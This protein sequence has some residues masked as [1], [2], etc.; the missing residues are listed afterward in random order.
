MIVELEN[1]DYQDSAELTGLAAYVRDLYEEFRNSDY[2][3]R[4]IDEINAAKK[5]YQLDLPPKSFPWKDCANYTLALERIAVESIEPRLMSQLI[6][7]DNFVNP[8][9]NGPE[10]VKHT[11]HVRDSVNWMLNS[12]MKIKKIFRP[13]LH[14]LC[15]DGTAD[16]IPVWKEGT[17]QINV[18]YPQPVFSMGDKEVPVSPEVMENPQ[19]MQS[20]AQM[21]LRFAGYK[22]GFRNEDSHWFMTDLEHVP[23]SDAFFP[24]N[25]DNWEN[26]PY[27]RMIYPTL[28][29]LDELS[30]EDG[31]Y[32]NIT[33]DLV[34]DPERMNNDEPD[35]DALDKGIRFSEY[36]KEIRVLEAYVLWENEWI[37]AAFCPDS[38]WRE[39][40][41]QPLL[42]IYPHGKKPVIRFVINKES[43]ESM[44]NGIPH[45][46]RHFSMGAD[47]LYNL[48][49]DSA[50][51]EIVPRGLIEEG[52][53]LQDVD[54]SFVLGEMKAIPKGSQ[55]HF[56][57]KGGLQAVQLINFI[58]LLMGFFER[59][60]S[61][62]DSVLPGNMGGRQGK[63]TETYSGM[64]L[65]QAESNI[66]HQYQGESVRDIMERLVTDCVSLYRVFMPMDAQMRIW[67]ESKNTWIFQPFNWDALQS[68]YDF[69]L[70]ISD[71]SANKTLNRKEAVERLQLFGQI[72]IINLPKLV[73]D[74]LKSYDIKATSEYILPQFQMIVQA[75]QSAPELAQ[76]IQQYMQ[77]RAMKEKEKKLQAEAVQNVKRHEIQRN[78]EKSQGEVLENQ[79]IVDQVEEST[80][81]KLV[82]PMVE[83][84]V[85]QRLG[86]M[87]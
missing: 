19:M 25:W 3:Q 4:K 27:L 57:P 45:L 42:E 41:R 38:A 82:Q 20:I 22:E 63:G 23:L 13:I 85:V 53:G 10:D 11:D 74:A 67:N 59:M 9:P 44:G 26:A 37:L 62:M 32:A 72:P 56:F 71:S 18:R 30:G 14:D 8:I 81:R 69:A 51:N 2:R 15:I 43:N 77:Q 17:R 79:K 61:L 86:G 6:G 73:E 84:S 64:A 70:E 65:I 35:D 52:P 46:V 60:M 33:P 49:V 31:P 55:P 75:L 36:T 80:K 54:F 5:R 28:Y 66:R 87:R 40:R 78:A 58:Q 68:E 29:E 21:G 47:D 48:M 34:V 1:K 16:V 83:Q 7:E 76:V 50:I 24:D 12:S 39:I